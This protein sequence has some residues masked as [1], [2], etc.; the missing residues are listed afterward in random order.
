MALRLVLLLALALLPLGTT[1]AS[2]TLPV[3]QV[4]EKRSATPSA[5]QEVE[6]R[7]TPQQR[8]ELSIG[9]RQSNLHRLES[10]LLAI[11][12]IGRASCRER[13]S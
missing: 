9:L 8:F 6:G 10:E 3:R 5:W 12:E 1:L 2:P 11:S 7:P 13:V 4:V